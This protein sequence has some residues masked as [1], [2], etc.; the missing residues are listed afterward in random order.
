METYKVTQS[1][2][3]ERIADVLC[4]A[5]EGGS[6]YWYMIIDKIEPRKWVFPHER[7]AKAVNSTKYLHEY[8]FNE[9]GALIINDW[10]AEEP[11]LK[12][13]VRL[14]SERIAKG[15]QIMAESYAGH[16]AD[17]VAENDDA[18][19]ADVF[20]QCCIFGKCIYG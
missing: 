4:N 16:F 7:S 12:D 3:A 2:S 6:N 1:V 13:P 10:S 14:D 11:E 18:E 17:L 5:L 19:T 20:L 9:G 15:L 8:P